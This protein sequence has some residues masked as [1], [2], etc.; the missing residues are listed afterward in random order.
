[1]LQITLKRNTCV[2]LRSISVPGFTFLALVFHYL[3]LLKRKHNTQVF[4]TLVKVSNFSNINDHKSFTKLKEVA[5]LTLRAS[6][7]IRPSFLETGR[8]Q[9]GAFQRPT[10]LLSFVKNVQLVHTFD[11]TYQQ[12]GD[13]DSLCFFF[14]KSNGLKKLQASIPW[15]GFEPR[16]KICELHNTIHVASVTADISKYTNCVFQKSRVLVIVP[17]RCSQFFT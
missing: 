6:K 12:H 9:R 4:I 17:F 11:W 8:L 3:W 15:V 13:T 1:M 10:P 5:L 14:R 2:W 7:F 16:L